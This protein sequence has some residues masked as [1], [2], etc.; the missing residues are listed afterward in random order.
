VPCDLRLLVGL[1]VLAL[2]RRCGGAAAPGPAGGVLAGA[3]L[4][5]S[6]AA[7][8]AGSARPPPPP[9]G[10]RRPRGPD[11]GPL[12]RDRG[13]ARGPV[14]RPRDAALGDVAG[15][16]QVGSPTTAPEPRRGDRLIEFDNNGRRPDDR[17]EAPQRIQK[18][19]DLE[20]ARRHWAPRARTRS[21]VR[22]APRARE[23]AR[24]RRTSS[25]ILSLARVQEK[26]GRRG[27]AGAELEKARLDL[28]SF[29]VSSRRSRELEIA[30]DKGGS[31]DRV[32]AAHPR[33]AR[34]EGS[35]ERHLRHR[36][37]W[38]RG[39]QVADRRLHVARSGDRSIP[40]LSLMEAVGYLATSTTT[41]STRGCPRAASSTPTRADLHRQGR[42]GRTVAEPA[43]R[44]WCASRSRPR[45]PPDAAGHVREDRGRR[46]AW[47]RPSRCRDRPCVRTTRRRRPAG[48]AHGKTWVIARD[49]P[50][51]SR[52]SSRLHA[53]RLRRRVGPSGR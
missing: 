52:S 15:P 27:E 47:R 50:T 24:A 34:R 37:E 10:G 28:E 2:S 40:D 44:L 33:R 23:K 39:P 3:H 9:S 5:A 22:G 17:R 29:T 18:G 13:A 6:G 38:E 14:A 32:R 49:L 16:D 41:G 4:P 53:D 42:G 45:T 30:L 35:E 1:L 31:R 48:A 19:I 51:P 7:G 46:H 26:Q 20:S 43:P 12:P 25:E 36:R 11:R 8:Q 21:S